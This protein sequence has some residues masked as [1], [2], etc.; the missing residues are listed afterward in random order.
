MVIIPGDFKKPCK[1]AVGYSDDGKSNQP[2]MVNLFPLNGIRLHISIGN[3][4]PY[5]LVFFAS[6][7]IDLPIKRVRQ[8]TQEGRSI[9]QHTEIS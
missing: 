5:I 6:M 2:V 7:A 3:L 1:Q 8:K 9:L 4:I